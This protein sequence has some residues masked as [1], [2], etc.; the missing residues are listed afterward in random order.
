MDKKLFNANKNLKNKN[1]D[2]ER[3]TKEFIGKEIEVLDSN[4]VVYSGICLAISHPYL[5]VVL[6]T[7]EGQI[8]IRNISNMKVR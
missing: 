3:Y 5:N 2:Y 8:I 1:S 4:N 6:K 7:E